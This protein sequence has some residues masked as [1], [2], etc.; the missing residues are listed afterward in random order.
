MVESLSSLTPVTTIEMENIKLDDQPTDVEREPDV[1][2]ATKDLALNITK[3][4]SKCT[5][6]Q[7]T[8]TYDF[9]SLPKSMYMKAPAVSPVEE[10]TRSPS[11]VNDM[12]KLKLATR[13][14]LREQR[15]RNKRDVGRT[16]IFT[17]PEKY[18]NPCDASVNATDG[19]SEEMDFLETFCAVARSKHVHVDADAAGDSRGCRLSSSRLNS[20]KSPPKKESIDIPPVKRLAARSTKGQHV[21][22][23]SEGSEDEEVKKKKKPPKKTF[24]PPCFKPLPSLGASSDPLSG[25]PLAGPEVLFRMPA[26][27]IPSPRMLASSPRLRAAMTFFQTEVID[28]FGYS[29]FSDNDAEEAYSEHIKIAKQLEKDRM[30]QQREEAEHKNYVRLMESITTNEV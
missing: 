12:L 14:R 29:S 30:R 11:T 9:A 24:I 15:L 16:D 20:C 23:E 1:K 4:T 27:K 17:N 6:V 2:Q 18:I 10:P 3:E 7:D 28:E 8:S 13:A 22:F 21:V 5:E 26:Q 19:T 25:P